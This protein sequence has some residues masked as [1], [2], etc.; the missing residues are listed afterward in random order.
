MINLHQSMGPGRDQTR[1]SWICSQTCYNCAMRLGLASFELG[2]NQYSMHILF[3]VTDN[4]PSE[5]AEG[6]RRMTVENIPKSISTKVWGRA[7]IEL[8]TP[9]SAIGLAT[10]C[11]L[12]ALLIL[13]SST[14]LFFLNLLILHYDKI[15]IESQKN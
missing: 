5:S 7:G 2:V 3:L 1:K 15:R 8:M 11:E 9:G 13:Y 6:S 10:G 14:I 12:T 4:S